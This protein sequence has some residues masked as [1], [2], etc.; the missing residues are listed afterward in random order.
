MATTTRF[1]ADALREFATAAFERAG[2][3]PEDAALTADTLIAADLRGVMSHGMVRLPIYVRNLRD[4]AVS[5][6][7]QPVLVSD[8]PST[9]LLDGQNAMGQVVGVRGMDLAIEKARASGVASV[10]VR[11]SNHFGT[12]AYYAL[13]AAEHDML[14]MAATNGA[15][16]M[17]PWGGIEPMVGNNP[18]AVAAP[19]GEAPIVSTWR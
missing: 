18:L 15:A 10:G 4:G 9:A 16:A 13:R 12:C 17:A 2:M 19:A 11:N 3:T 5:A 6:T 7:A 14:G 8:S 1:A